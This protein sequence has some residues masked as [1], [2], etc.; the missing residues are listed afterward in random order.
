MPSKPRNCVAKHMNTFNK[1]VTMKDRKKS[2]KSN[3]Q[4]KNKHKGK[5]YA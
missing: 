3:G 4:R 2:A 5:H 1:A